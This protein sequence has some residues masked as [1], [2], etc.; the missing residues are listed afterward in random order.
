MDNFSILG[1]RINPMINSKGFSLI[2]VL[3]S[4]LILS[5]ISSG[6]FLFIT[7]A[8]RSSMDSY[9]EFMAL[10]VAREPIEIFKCFGYERI[11]KAATDPIADYKINQWQNVLQYSSQT[12]I[13]RPQ[14]TEFLER[15]IECTPVNDSG[16]KGVLIKVTVRAFKPGKIKTY[17]R[18]GEVDF[19][20]II[21]EQ[22]Q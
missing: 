15:N 7:G 12:G 14:E 20:S 16:I 6:I 11:A 18:R 1:D 4:I 2:E 19:S 9:Y 8:N 3:V 17:V 10:Q 21:W 13:D 5:I 22:P